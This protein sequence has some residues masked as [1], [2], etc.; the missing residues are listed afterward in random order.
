MNIDD[1]KRRLQQQEQEL[2]T[3]IKQAGASAHEPADDE[4]AGGASASVE[5][6]LKA[7]ELRHV[8]AESTVLTQVREALKRI[9]NGT[10]GRCVV[11][12]GPIEEK[13]LETIPWTP[14]CLKHQ[15]ELEGARPPRTATL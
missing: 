11:D 12:G 7:M 13:R 6:E 14:Y 10:F 5:N 15:H 2:S 4:T 9:E 8:D 3:W 1:Y